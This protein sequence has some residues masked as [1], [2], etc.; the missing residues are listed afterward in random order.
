VR[1]EHP[2]VPRCGTPLNISHVLSNARFTV[3]RIAYFIP[4][5][6]YATSLAI[7]T[8][9]CLAFRHIGLLNR[10]DIEVFI[11]VY[12]IGGSRD[13]S[14]GIAIGYGLEN[15]GVGVP[16]PVVQEFSLLHVFQI[17][18]GVHPTSYTIDTGSSFLGGKAA[19]GVK[20]TT[21]LQLLPRSRKCGS[22][23]PLP[24]TPSWRSA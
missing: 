16:V 10:Y 14:V 7:I 17:G 21:H 1:S 6:R 4:T 2:F 8:L 19:G 18:S 24:H 3:K 12:F 15:G 13:S 11:F 9:T 22:I 23:H 20:L 5:A